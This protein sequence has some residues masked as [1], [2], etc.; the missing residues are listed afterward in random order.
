[1][2]GFIFHSQGAALFD[3]FSQEWIAH[4]GLISGVDLARGVVRLWAPNMDTFGRG[5]I[6]NLGQGSGGLYDSSLNFVR[7][8]NVQK[9][10]TAMVSAAGLVVLRAAYGR[11]SNCGLCAIW[12]W[13]T[14][15]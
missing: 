8:Q 6:I 15:V 1:M 4:G 10:H 2:Q 5:S 11:C 13:C 12:R 9:T 3:D 7:E 14:V